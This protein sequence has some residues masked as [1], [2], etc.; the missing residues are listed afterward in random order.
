[1]PSMR[2]PW[3]LRGIQTLPGGFFVG[4]TLPKVTVWTTGKSIMMASCRPTAP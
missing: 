2:E 1:M 4:L 3:L